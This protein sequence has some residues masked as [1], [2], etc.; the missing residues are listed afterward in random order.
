MG[1][2]SVEQFWYIFWLIKAIISLGF[3]GAIILVCTSV[4][5][6]IHSKRAKPVSFKH[7]SVHS[8]GALR[9]YRT[10]D[11]SESKAVNTT[12]RIG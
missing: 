7:T 9:S 1:G 10:F 3:V 11:A 6:L 8:L 5:G 12:K 2:D 4:F